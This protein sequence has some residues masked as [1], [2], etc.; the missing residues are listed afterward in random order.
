M[1][2]DIDPIDYMQAQVTQPTVT[3]NLPVDTA[4]LKPLR[5]P[6]AVVAMEARIAELEAENAA[7]RAELKKWQPLNYGGAVVTIP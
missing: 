1:S 3:H 7:L 4:G 2:N 5:K 6:D